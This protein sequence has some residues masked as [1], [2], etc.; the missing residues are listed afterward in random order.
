MR[1]GAATAQRLFRQLQQH[2]AVPRSQVIAKGR[3]GSSAL[4]EL[5]NCREEEQLDAADAGLPVV[6]ELRWDSPLQVLQYPHPKLRA[7]NARLGVFDDNLRQLVAEMF[8]IMYRDEGVGLAAPQVGVNIRLMVFNAEGERG[9][10]E[11]LVL[12]NPRII[13]SSR[14]QDLQEEGCLSFRK[15]KS[16]ELILGDVKR[17]LKVKVKAQDIN[18]QK[19]Q[20]SFSDWTARIFQHEYDH[21]QGTLFPDHVQGESRAKMLP[22]L[23]QLENSYLQQQPNESIQRYQ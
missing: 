23:Q 12:A 16:S 7:Q 8:D 3:R 2:H 19:F 6:E 13:S 20:R 4:R 5:E 14:S 18:G 1:R 10:G 21:L 9:K 11:E 17:Q 15:L 22:Y